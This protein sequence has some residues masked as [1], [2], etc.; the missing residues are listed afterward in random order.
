[1]WVD[2][3]PVRPGLAMR[4]RM[5][6]NSLFGSGYA[7]MVVAVTPAVDWDQL[8]PAELRAAGESVPAFLLSHPDLER[9][10][11]ALSAR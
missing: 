9:T 8:K 6:M 10:V 5:A 4:G 2:G 3:M 1:M 11:A 7:P